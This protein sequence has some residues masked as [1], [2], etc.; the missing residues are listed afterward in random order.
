MRKGSSFSKGYFL[1]LRKEYCYVKSYNEVGRVSSSWTYR[2]WHHEPYDQ[3][4]VVMTEVSLTRTYSR[5]YFA[6]AV[7]AAWLLMLVGPGYAQTS[8]ED[9]ASHHPDQAN[10]SSQAAGG[11]RQEA[12]SDNRGSGPGGMM[13][14]PGG[15]GMMGGGMDKMMEKM[16]APKPKALY[17][18]LMSL[19]DLPIEQRAEVQQ[20]A[21]ERMKQ[22]TGLMAEGLKSLSQSAP[23]NDFIA[24]Q[25]ATRKLH[26][27]L[28]QFESGLA[29]HR[30]LEEGTPPRN[31]A[32]HWFKQEMNLL[33]PQERLQAHGI[34]GLSW[35]H[36]YMM[37]LLIAF[38]VGILFLYFFKMRRAAAL[39][40]RLAGDSGPANLAPVA[41]PGKPEA[42]ATE[43]K[44]SEAGD[45]PANSRATSAHPPASQEAKNQA[46][47]PAECC[48]VSNDVCATEEKPTD[49]PDI[50]T[51][52]LPVAK[53]K[54]CRLRVAQIYQETVDVKTF[55]LVACHGGGIPFSY[56]PGQFLTLTLPT[57]DRSIR[58]SYTISSSPTQGYYCEI[59]VKREEHGAGSRYLHDVVKEGDTLE[60]QAP[61]G[62][63]VF[64]G[65]EADSVVLISGGVGITPM[66]SITCALT[67][68]GWDGD[69]YFIAACRDPEHFI[70]ASE[71]KKLQERHPNLHVFVAMSRLDKEV[72]GCH[73]GRI[74]KD[75]LAQ[76]VP[77]LS[78]QWI[79][80]CGAP[81]M[82][83]AVKQMLA[84]LGASGEM[85]HT[86]NFGSQQ[87][88]QARVAE[89]ERARPA[90][91]AAKTGRVTFQRADKSTELLP[92]ETVLEASERVA[93]DI[94]YSCRTGSCG[95]C[96]VKLLS[97][98]VIMEV[99]D[100][101]DPDDKVAGMILACQA[102]STSNLAVDA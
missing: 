51:G 38:A 30:A 28:S 100:G 18:S 7:I 64:T 99:E 37:V 31:V 102:K 77:D 72:D 49:R 98:S 1:K 53:K 96:K 35:F 88:P 15:G 70:F 54:L 14:G 95:V 69:I 25:E 62:K 36:F 5:R 8:P 48:D 90:T 85:I 89:R 92:D 56:L 57:G 16:G 50:S 65:K 39:L 6:V 44:S 66:M 68:M 67:D 43:M 59:T 52:L 3:D 81:P 93:V 24:M 84:E 29:A 17:P 76:W 86:E 21:H 4:C 101:L 27:G 97:G 55:R 87:K 10:S 9:H 19:P 80:L 41:A 46:T 91:P 78:A 79:H 73:R 71:L 60:V 61:S 58:R 74:S 45:T 11:E 12:S 33:P 47:A 82:M 40:K 13:G 75:L 26:E 94:D 63:F 20:Q 22:G 2:L 83:D 42:T 32:L 34:L 23:T